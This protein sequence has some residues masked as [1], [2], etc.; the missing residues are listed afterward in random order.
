MFYGIYI[1]HILQQLQTQLNAPFFL[2]TGPASATMTITHILRDVWS[3]LRLKKL[4]TDDNHFYV[5]YIFIKLQFRKAV[6][7]KCQI[8]D[9]ETKSPFSEKGPEE[10]NSVFALMGYSR[11]DLTGMLLY[12]RV[13]TNTWIYFQELHELFLSQKDIN[14]HTNIQLS[15][16][17]LNVQT[18][19]IPHPWPSV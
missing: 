17:W 16:M 7:C 13:H 3:P 14:T 15:S 12:L 19:S 18:N 8:W 5:S 9:D 11:F 1:D 4:V 10:Q 2:P 6:F